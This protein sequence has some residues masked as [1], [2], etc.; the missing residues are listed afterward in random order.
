[1]GGGPVYPRRVGTERH[2]TERDGIYSTTD[3]LDDDQRFG[4]VFVCVRM[5]MSCK[6][7]VC[8]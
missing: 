1:M 4:L 8:I 3:D 5:T 6:R 7:N 2:G